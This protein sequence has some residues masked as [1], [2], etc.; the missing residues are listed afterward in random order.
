MLGGICFGDDDIRVTVIGSVA[1][2][3]EEG[4]VMHHCV[5]ENGYYSKRRH[6]FSLILSAKDREGNRL[7]TVEVSTRTWDVVQSRGVCNLPSEHHDRIV[8][9]VERNM[10]LLKQAV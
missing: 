8:E 1:E 9:L 3:A 10:N 7:E 2:M 5:Y 6:P 4:A